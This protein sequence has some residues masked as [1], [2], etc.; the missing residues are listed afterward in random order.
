M[1]PLVRSVA[2]FR[3]AGLLGIAALSLVPTP[4]QGQSKIPTKVNVPELCS[5]DSAAVFLGFA[6]RETRA[7]RVFATNSAQ[8]IALLQL[9]AAT[10]AQLDKAP[11]VPGDKTAV[12]GIFQHE[13]QAWERAARELADSSANR[14]TLV[15]ESYRH[16]VEAA[17][18]E[19]GV[20]CK[21]RLRWPVLHAAAREAA[22]L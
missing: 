1:N 22:A 5:A 6:V 3:L 2:Y 4:G 12:Y 19:L 9:E 21:G 18:Q 17:S 16:Y 14:D 8:R 15:H 11:L 10:I 7:A 20:K 13:D